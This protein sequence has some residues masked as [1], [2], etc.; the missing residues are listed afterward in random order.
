MGA[1]SALLDMA[2]RMAREYEV[3]HLAARVDACLGRV[4][5]VLAGFRE[6]QLL[7]WQS[8]AGQAYRHSVA[9]QEV[10]LGRARVR[11]EDARSAVT[12]CAQDVG[13]SE[14]SPAGRNQPAGLFKWP[15]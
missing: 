2:A 14:V 6:I 4:E 10:A 15:R 3:R 13:S 7:N 9:L 8:P 1:D 5:R 12:R 11:L